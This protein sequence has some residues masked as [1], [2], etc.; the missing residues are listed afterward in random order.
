MA[1]QYTSTDNNVNGLLGTQNYAV[2][3]I[4]KQYQPKHTILFG[5]RVRGKLRQQ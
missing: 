2:D 4:V 1:T 5:T 3:K